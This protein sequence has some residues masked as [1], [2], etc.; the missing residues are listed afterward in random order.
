MAQKK[1]VQSEVQVFYFTDPC[2]PWCWASEPK[3][4][5]MME[6]YGERIRLVYKMGGFMEKWTG[7]QVGDQPIRKPI[8][9]APYWIEISR[10]T[11]VPMDER[12]WKS[13]PPLSSY[14]ACIAFKAAEMQG[15][16]LALRYLRRLREAVFLEQKNTAEEAVLFR[17]AK[18]AG[19]KIDRFRRDFKEGPAESAFRQDLEESR[20]QFILG[21]PTLF[22]RGGGGRE[23][24]LYGYREYES[25]RRAIDDVCRDRVPRVKP[26]NISA[27]IKRYGGALLPEVV[28][29]FGLEP[30]EAESELEALRRK[31]RL[32][33]TSVG[34]GDV[35]WLPV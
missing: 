14:P 18:Q 20:E 19:L 11:G 25:Y 8:Q 15:A 9:M 4:R 6:E 28:E 21:F 34:N 33:R 16:R 24:K 13:N 27:F 31:R 12:I 22:F 35:L 1:G 10:R 26:K 32:R 30:E 2:C 3:I 17:L 29:V 5:R 23:A 7:F